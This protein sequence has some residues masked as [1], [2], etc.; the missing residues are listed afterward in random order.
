MWTSKVCFALYSFL[1][2]A[3]ISLQHAWQI[4]PGEDWLPSLKITL[5]GLP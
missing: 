5:E 4:H 3:K 1:P 2:S